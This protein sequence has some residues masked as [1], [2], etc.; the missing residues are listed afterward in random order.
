MAL[1]VAV[2]TASAVPFNTHEPVPLHAPDQ[3]ANVESLSGFAVSV[4]E[5]PKGKLTLQIDPQLMPA[6]E[7]VTVPVPVPESVTEI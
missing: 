6:G 1:N 3:P 2:T 7:L 5:I 4:A